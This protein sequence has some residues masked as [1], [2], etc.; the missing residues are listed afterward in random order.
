M[1]KAEAEA[2]LLLAENWEH[3]IRMFQPAQVEACGHNLEN[4]AAH[5]RDVNALEARG[6]NC[7]QGCTKCVMAPTLKAKACK[8]YN[9]AIM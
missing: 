7:L 6:P 9:C 3:M 5:A 1:Q 4:H 2:R 8:V